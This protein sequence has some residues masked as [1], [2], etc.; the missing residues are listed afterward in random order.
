MD[1]YR[2]SG[3]FG[4]RLALTT[5][6]ASAVLAASAEAGVAL[7]AFVP[8][9][10]LAVVTLAG[11]ALLTFVVASLAASSGRSRN[12]TAGA[13]AGVVVALA[14][15]V[16]GH[17]WSYR[18]TLE[19]VARGEMTAP[20]PASFVDSFAWRLERGY[21]VVAR[22]RVG[23]VPA[24]RLGGVPVLLAWLAEALVLGAVGRAAGRSGST[25]P[26]CEACDG[27][28]RRAFA[29]VPSAPER[30]ACLRAAAAPAELAAL[31]PPAPGGTTV[32]FSLDHCPQCQRGWLTVA[33]RPASGP[34]EV[35]HRDVPLPAG[36]AAPLRAAIE[37]ANQAATAGK[38]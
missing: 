25:D 15:V 20:G 3:R 8:H 28:T 14:G 18:R 17:A 10:S 22:T 7:F 34:R 37:A 38:A 29:Y 36:Q 13:V 6:I 2:P 1:A 11:N 12:T 19:L 23:G 26:Y 27:P 9:W 33:L 5:L 32:V 21:A 24:G 16:G 4:L 30:V 31:G 35:L